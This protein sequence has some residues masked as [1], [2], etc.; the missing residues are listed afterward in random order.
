MTYLLIYFNI[1]LF[2]KKKC[3]LHRVKINKGFFLNIK[4]LIILILM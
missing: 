4:N 2:I 1:I 3:S